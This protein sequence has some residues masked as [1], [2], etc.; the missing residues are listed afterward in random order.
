MAPTLD[1]AGYPGRDSAVNPA[2]RIGGE[3]YAKRYLP[4][5]YFFVWFVCGGGVL[6]VLVLTLGA[7]HS[8]IR[9]CN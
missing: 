3:F 4:E 1:V 6:L 7:K 5:V 9:Y 2:F 8:L